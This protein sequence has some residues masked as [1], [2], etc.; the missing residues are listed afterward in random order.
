[1]VEET[2]SKERKIKE[3]EE[4]GEEVT[5]LHFSFRENSKYVNFCDISFH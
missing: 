5:K 1:M 2:G 3:G 4:E